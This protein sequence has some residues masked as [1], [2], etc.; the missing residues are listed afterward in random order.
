MDGVIGAKSWM[1]K[2]KDFC[3]GDDL[4]VN[5]QET[6]DAFGYVLFESINGRQ[7]ILSGNF[8]SA[9]FF[10]ERGV[11]LR[12]GDIANDNDI[13]LIGDYGIYFF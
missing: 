9:V 12:N 3:G 5:F 11:N 4:I 1:G 2:D 7:K 6:V 8:T 13:I 10:A